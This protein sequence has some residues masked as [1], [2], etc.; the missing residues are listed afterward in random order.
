MIR[1]QHHSADVRGSFV[2]TMLA[3]PTRARVHHVKVATRVWNRLQRLD[4]R[5]LDGLLAVALTVGAC[6]QLLSQQPESYLKL[7]PVSFTCLPLVLRRRYPIL[8]HAVQ[9]GAAIATQQEPVTL[10]LVAIFIGV[11]SVAVY[12]RWR[13][14]FLIWL[15]IGAA[16]LGIAFPESSPSMPSWALMLVVGVGVWL[17]GNSVRGRQQ[18]VDLLEERAIRLE[19]ERELSMRVARADERQRIARELHDVVAHSVSVMVVQA[20]AARSMLRRQPDQSVEALLAVESSGRMALGELRRM[21]GLLT[22]V[23]PAPELSPQPGLN[24]LDALVARVSQAG[25]PVDVHVR[26]G[27][28]DISPGLDLTAYRIIQEALTNSLKH[29]SGAKADVFIDYSD[30]ELRI[31]VVDSGGVALSEA[32]GSGRGLLGM[33]ERVAMYGGRLEIGRQPEGGF[34]VRALL[35]LESGG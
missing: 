12:S 26:G 13:R 31:E 17:A 11:Y 21:L 20:G 14:A 10:S 3:S 15:L 33:R 22:E 27:R 35:P 23:E 32:N 34:A 18:R 16:W 6:L 25:L 1:V 4:P 5:L 8:A 7:I 30:R 29:A 2:G 9:I 28:A 24:Q 19:R